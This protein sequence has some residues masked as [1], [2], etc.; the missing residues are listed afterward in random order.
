MAVGLLAQSMT[1][2]QV[3]SFVKTSAKKNPDKDVAEYLKKITLTDRLTDD[4]I[5]ACVQ[6]GAGQKTQH[7]LIELE[8][9]SGGLPEAPKPAAPAVKAAEAPSAG[10][11]PKPVGP[12]A[13]SDEKKREVIE[14]A[15]EYAQGYVKNLPSFTCTQV[16]KKFYDTSR[17]ENWQMRDKVVEYLSYSDGREFYNVVTVND[18]MMPNADHW[19]VG[20]T[21]SSGEFGTDMA[22]LFDPETH[23]EFEW[24]SWTKWHGR[25]AHKIFYRVRQPYSRYTIEYEKTQK[26]IP[27]YKGYVYVDRDLNMI[28]RITRETEDMPADFPIKEVKTE[29]NYEFTKIGDEGR[30]FLVPA[31]SKVTSK[32]VR[33][34]SKN[35]IEFRQYRKFEVGTKFITEAPP[36]E[37]EKPPTPPPAKK[38]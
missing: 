34:L 7:A 37:S 1:S 16:T 18:K 11:P 36:E 13:P 27:G 25:V 9:K 4:A 5:E 17:G 21:T 26:T 14:K 31:E 32:A 8:T 20:G 2:A 10:T 38:Q 19:A 6:A 23:A 22:A 30:E 12:P 3:V 29:T 24:E 33:Q 15:T 28:L 35:E